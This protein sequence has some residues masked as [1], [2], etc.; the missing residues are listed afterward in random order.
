MTH[1]YFLLLSIYL[2]NTVNNFI[3]FAIQIPPNKMSCLKEWFPDNESIAINFD[4][5]SEKNTHKKIKKKSKKYNEIIHT[6]FN[7]KKELLGKV[8][9]QREPWTFVTHEDEI[10]TLCANNTSVESVIIEYNITTNVY[11]NDHSRV[12]DKSHLKLYE[13]DINDL[14]E[15]TK[16]LVSDNRIVYER[17]K[18]RQI[19][20]SN[21]SG[22]VAEF[23]GLGILFII[24]IKVCGICYLRRKL[25]QKKML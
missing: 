4:I 2:I 23:S 8:E 21:L 17:T 22:M 9:Y 14:E 6:F 19:K 18:N 11:N 5:L 7:E 16:S 12:A 1:K 20:I 25:Y 3:T 13:Q 15:L 24:M 10:I